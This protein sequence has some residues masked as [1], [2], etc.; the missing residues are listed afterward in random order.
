MLQFTDCGKADNP[1]LNNGLTNSAGYCACRK[2]NVPG[3]GQS[4]GEGSGIAHGERH[5][6]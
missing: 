4:T 3:C 6:D 1:K 2:K 5:H